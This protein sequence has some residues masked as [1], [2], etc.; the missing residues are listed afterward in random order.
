MPQRIIVDH[1]DYRLVCFQLRL[2]TRTDTHILMWMIS[3]FSV[4]IIYLFIFIINR[5]TPKWLMYMWKV[6]VFN[7]I[8]HEIKATTIS[9]S[10]HNKM[11]RE[12]TK[13]SEE[14][15]FNFLK[16]TEQLRLSSKCNVSL[17]L[18]ASTQCV[19]YISKWIYFLIFIYLKK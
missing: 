16:L 15:C 9:N 12:K 18:C 3:K 13:L 1:N 19:P 17:Y 8:W 11:K 10:N 2:I 14:K 4:F 5:K 6:Y 7:W